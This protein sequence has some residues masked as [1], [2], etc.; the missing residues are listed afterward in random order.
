MTRRW[1]WGIG[2]TLVYAVFATGTIGFVVFAMQQQVDLVSADYY[3]Q[4]LVHDAKMAATSRGASLG[5]AFSVA[6]EPDARNLAV[7]WPQG[8]RVE[9]GQIT[10]YRASDA[11]SDRAVPA[12][13]DAAG[14]QVV[15]LDGMDR[16]AWI[17][18]VDWTA[19]GRSYFAERRITLP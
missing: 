14:R 1:H 5:E 13:P 18:R 7:A 9:A 10:L 15:P 6:V 8:M 12:A 16:G 11:R 17:V 2:V 3:P 4:S 19:G